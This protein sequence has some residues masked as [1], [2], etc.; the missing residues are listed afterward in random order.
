MREE[1]CA[2]G[3]AASASSG[4]MPASTRIRPL[5]NARVSASAWPAS[6]WQIVNA[7]SP[8]AWSP[9]SAART[10]SSKS[11]SA[12]GLPPCACASSS[13]MS[14]THCGALDM[15]GNVWEWVNDWYQEDYYTVSPYNNP[16]GPVTGTMKVLRGG[17]WLSNWF[18]LRVANRTYFN[19]AGQYNNLGFRCVS[20]PGG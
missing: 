6:C 12:G 11:S 2:S 8:W 3:S 17:S 1:R 10:I 19:P 5:A 18:P 7:C 4:L 16:Q 15:A 9:R 20:A 14:A 13:S